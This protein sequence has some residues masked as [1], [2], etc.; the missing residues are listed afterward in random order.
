MPISDM[1]WSIG[2]NVYVVFVPVYICDTFKLD[3]S[4]QKKSCYIGSSFVF[5]IS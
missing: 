2:A 1:L 5:A 4:L 3:M